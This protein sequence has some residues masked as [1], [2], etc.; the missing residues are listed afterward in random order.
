MTSLMSIFDPCSSTKV[1]NWACGAVIFFL[2]CSN[3]WELSSTNKIFQKH[4]IKL[5]TDTYVMM[6]KTTLIFVAMFFFFLINNLLGLFPFGFSL[7]SH[8][9]Y[10]FFFGATFWFATN[11]WGFTKNLS[12]NLAHFTPEGCPPLLIP[13]M[14]LVEMLSALIRP[15]TLSLRLMSNM[16]A[17]HMILS[18]LSKA[19]FALSW[20]LSP[21]FFSLELGFLLFESG[22]SFIQAYVFTTLMSL[23]WGESEGH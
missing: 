19:V 20:Y 2:F 8:F 18:L 7:T 9:L 23:Y 21:L 12:S 5:M 1:S 13:F 6:K 22:V 10:N 4:L 14:V 15:I 3:Y 17:G 11:L 16:M